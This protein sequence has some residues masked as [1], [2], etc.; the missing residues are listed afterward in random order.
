MYSL[1]K[2]LE[3]IRVWNKE[4]F[5]KFKFGIKKGLISLSLKYRKTEKHEK[6]G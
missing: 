2:G 1:K 6:H 3:N 4:I 5:D